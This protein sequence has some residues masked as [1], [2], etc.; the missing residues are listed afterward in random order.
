VADFTTLF[1]GDRVA[2]DRFEAKYVF[3]E[4]AGLVEVERR[5]TYM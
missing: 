2:H 1:H 4:L 3:V 5:K